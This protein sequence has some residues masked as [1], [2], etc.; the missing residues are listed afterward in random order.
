VS[1]LLG[2]GDG[3]FQAGALFRAGAGR[4][5]WPNSVVVADLDGDQALDLVT[6]NTARGDDVTV[7]LGNGDGSFQPFTSFAVGGYNSYDVAVADLD[8]DSVLDLVTANATDYYSYNVGSVSILL[9]NG[10]GSFQAAATFAVGDLPSYSVAVADLDGDSILDL[11]TANA[12]DYYSPNV[13]N[14][15]ILLGNGD[16]SFQAATF[17]EVSD[18]PRS[19][20]VADLDG[21]SILDLVTANAGGYYSPNVGNVSV[22][23][24]NGDGTFQAAASFAAGIGANS[25]AVADLDGDS[26]LDLATANVGSSYTDFGSVSVLLGNGDGSFQAAASFVAGDTTAS[27]A[28]ADLDGDSLPDLVT[29]NYGNDNVTVLLNQG[30]PTVRTEIDIK[31]GSDSNPMN[32]SGQGNL[33]V[34]ILGSESLDVAEI[35]AATLT[36]GPARASY[37]HRGGPHFEDVNGDGFADLMAHYRIKE[38]GIAF[39]DIQACVSGET[40]DGTPFEACDSIRTVPD[41]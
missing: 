17:F 4:Y 16:G 38:T 22:L 2:N 6:S 18:R 8:G 24:G 20:A 13:G 39:G 1:V 9:G 26:I 25:V 40:L 34:A 36:F 14:V 21:D 23:L 15:S 32:P 28:V 41:R 37:V 27:V 12:G 29:A 3:S 30:E 31:P 11:V 7:L 35:D 19:V 10:D 5:V 33:P